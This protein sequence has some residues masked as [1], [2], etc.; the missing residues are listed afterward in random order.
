MSDFQGLY[1]YKVQIFWQYP[2]VK[3][4]TNQGFQELLG[5]D[6]E[7]EHQKG[8]LEIPVMTW[9]EVMKKEKIRDSVVDSKH[10]YQEKEKVDLKWEEVKVN[11]TFWK[12]KKMTILFWVFSRIIHW[13]EFSEWKKH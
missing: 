12:K 6:P 8:I 3:K 2:A 7:T 11:P 13:E 5:T 1:K 10:H 4:M 9:P